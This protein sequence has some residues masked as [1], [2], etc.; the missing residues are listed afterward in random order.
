MQLFL[1]SSGSAS[2]ATFSLIIWMVIIFGF[3]YFFMIRP[4]R[5]EQKNK[6][7]MIKE[8]AIGDTVLTTSGF[9][10]V[11]I[12]ISKD[13]D[14]VIVEF[15]SN[16]NCRIPMQTAAISAVEKPEYAKKAEEDAKKEAEEK[17]AKDAAK[18][19]KAASKSKDKKS[20]KS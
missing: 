17:K 8:L 5:K 13:Q 2:G 12:D 19:E 1:S 16:R 20:V 15:G 18:K 3:M 9:Y 6:D 7:A 14:T 4:Q 10:G 11:V